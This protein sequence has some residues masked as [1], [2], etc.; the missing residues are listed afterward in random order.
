MGLKVF[1]N[2]GDGGRA[3]DP[4]QVLILK[5]TPGSERKKDL[6]WQAFEYELTPV[7][8][9]PGHLFSREYQ[10]KSRFTIV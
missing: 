10:D 6:Y 7:S 8:V 3:G 5:A 2:S 9:L 4:F 1:A